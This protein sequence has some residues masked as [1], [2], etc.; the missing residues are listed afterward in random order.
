MIQRECFYYKALSLLYF[1]KNTHS[2]MKWVTSIWKE[3]VMK[4]PI[5]MYCEWHDDQMWEAGNQPT[6]TR[7]A[8]HGLGVG[9]VDGLLG[10][11]LTALGILAFGGI[12]K[13]VEK[14]RG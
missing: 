10:I 7:A 3:I 14:V 11:G 4:N 5:A 1:A 12:A 6:L 8:L 9:T 13:I 2:F